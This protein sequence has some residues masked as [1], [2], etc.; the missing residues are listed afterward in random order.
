[1]IRVFN[2]E[3]LAK[4]SILTLGGEA[5]E[6]MEILEDRI[7]V[8]KKSN[9]EEIPLNTMRGKALLD[10]LEYSGELTQEIYV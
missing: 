4:K 2:K 1:M 3:E 8:Y 6:K 9:V 5:P 10:R 7:R